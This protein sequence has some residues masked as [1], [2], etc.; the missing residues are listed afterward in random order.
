LALGVIDDRTKP[1][2]SA[3]CARPNGDDRTKIKL[4]RDA[5]VD[6]QSDA[7]AGMLILRQ[8]DEN[9]LNQLQ[10][11]EIIWALETIRK[12]N[13]DLFLITEDLSSSIR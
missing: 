1:E 5:L 11:R 10:R 12:D 7:F 2:S 13:K 6:A 8:T 9:Q 4:V 3:C